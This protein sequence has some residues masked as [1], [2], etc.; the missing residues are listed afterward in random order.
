[1]AKRQKRGSGDPDP[2][3]IQVGDV[4]RFHTKQDLSV[5]Q[6]VFSGPRPLKSTPY[7]VAEDTTRQFYQGETRDGWR[8]FHLINLDGSCIN[9]GSIS[10][11]YCSAYLYKDKFLS[12]AR[13]AASK[14]SK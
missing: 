2:L 5:D 7:L 4:V 6:Y 10:H 11:S 14:C 1:M 3:K 9:D 8:V 13:K 12:A